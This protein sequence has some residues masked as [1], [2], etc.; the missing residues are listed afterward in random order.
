MMPLSMGTRVADVPKGSPVSARRTPLGWPVVP[1]EYSMAN[2][3]TSAGERLGREREDEL[4][5]G[6]VALDEVVAQHESELDVGGQG[7]QVGGEGRQ[8]VRR[9]QGA[10]ATVVDDVGGLLGGEMRVD[11]GV[12]EPRALKAEGDLVRA[13]VVGEHDGDVIAGLEAVG[14]QRLGQATRAGL[15]LGERDDLTGRGDH[16]GRSGWSAT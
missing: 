3:S 10:C 13:V 8:R 4:V 9:D 6:A 14:G 16:G 5:V 1:D 7:H 12:E 11:H 15:E 2:P